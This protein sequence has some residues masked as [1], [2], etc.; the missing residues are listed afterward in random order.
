LAFHK[1]EKNEG[2]NPAAVLLTGG[3]SD[4][5]DSKT[6]PDAPE[7]GGGFCQPA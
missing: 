2:S 1:G 3:I 5:I 7:H 6:G 4:D